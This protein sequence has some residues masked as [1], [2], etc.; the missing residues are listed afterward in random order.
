MN[1]TPEDM[2]RLLYADGG[3]FQPKPRPTPTPAR[4][5]VEKPPRKQKTKQPTP[6]PVA[7]RREKPP[8]TATAP[9]PR[10]R[11][12]KQTKPKPS[13]EERFWAKV[14]RRSADECWIWQGAR[15][16]QGYGYLRNGSTT[17]LAAHRTAY[18]LTYGEIAPGMQLHHKC[19][20]R[21]CCN[22]AHLQQVTPGEHSLMEGHCA[23]RQVQ[24]THCPQGH[25]YD[26]V[27]DGSRR[28]S[29]C[30]RA[31]RRAYEKTD[32]YRAW[33][34]EYRRKWRADRT[35]RANPAT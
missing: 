12:V 2:Q 15:T 7:A 28:C 4:A 29:V 33:Q 22:P 20:N 13:F 1:L 6:K 32:A 17:N 14:D 11:R 8:K 34:R 3:G 27:S 23:G 26:Y 9:K 30:E 19:H 10:A 31:R 24:K 18:T 5:S 21:L 35:Q 16:R 25:P